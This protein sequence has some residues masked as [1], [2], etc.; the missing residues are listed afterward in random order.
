M[1]VRRKGKGKRQGFLH[2]PAAQPATARTET[3]EDGD[4]EETKIRWKPPQRVVT[5]LPTPPVAQT[6]LVTCSNKR[7]SELMQQVP[8]W[9]DISK[10]DCIISLTAIPTRV[11]H[12][13][14][15]RTLASLCEGQLLPPKRVILNVCEHY[16]RKF[17][18]PTQL[19]HQKLALLKSRFPQLYVNFTED[20]GPATK[21]LGLYNVPKEVVDVSKCNVVVVDDDFVYGKT[22]TQYHMLAMQLYQS[23]FVGIDERALVLWN[24]VGSNSFSFSGDG[25][26]TYHDIFYDNYHGY[27][28]GWMSFCMRG[29]LVH[30][31]KA[32]FHKTVESS[33]E[34]IS[35]DDLFFTLYYLDR[36]L[37]GV[38]MHMFFSEG[39]RPGS[40][41][42]DALRLR[43][44]EHSHRAAME[45]QAFAKANHTPDQLSKY[46]RWRPAKLA[47]SDSIPIPPRYL[48]SN[49]SNWEY[50]AT[51]ANHYQTTQYDLKYI[52]PSLM[53]LTVSCF[54]DPPLMTL[55]EKTGLSQL[56]LTLLRADNQIA[57]TVVLPWNR[58]AAARKATF[59]VAFPQNEILEQE[60]HQQR[61][62]PTLVQ[63][64]ADINVSCH[65]SICTIL[66]CMPHMPYRFF[67]DL[68]AEKFV[69]TT[70]PKPV[71]QTYQKLR[72]PSYRADLFRALYLWEHGGLYTDCK[73]V[74]YRS[75]RPYLA[76]RKRLYVRSQAEQWGTYNAV[77]YE[78]LPRSPVLKGY[79]TEAMY[80]V[81]FEIY[82]H[83]LLHVTGPCVLNSHVPKEDKILLKTNITVG[84]RWQES[85]FVKEEHGGKIIM[86]SS[87]YG[88]YEE[89]KNKLQHY[90]RY[91]ET[92]K[93]FQSL[94]Y[95]AQQK[96]NGIGKIV[97]INLDRCETRRQKMEQFLQQLQAVPNQRIPALHDETPEIDFARFIGRTKLTKKEVAC[98]LS[99]IKAITALRDAPGEWFLVVEDDLEFLSAY[100]FEQTL[101]EILAQAPE[102]AEIVKLH[103]LNYTKDRNLPDFVP[104]VVGRMPSTTAYAIRKSGVRH[105][106][107]KFR[108]TKNN[109]ITFPAKVQIA[110]ADMFIYTLAKTY[111]YRYNFF[112]APHD[113]STIHQQHMVWHRM[114]KMRN[115]EMMLWQLI[116]RTKDSLQAPEKPSHEPEEEEKPLY[117]PP[118]PPP[119]KD[120]P[121]ERLLQKQTMTERRKL[122][123]RRVLFAN[124]ANNKEQ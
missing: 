39:D 117:L 50:H 112:E 2:D 21:F 72:A 75:L 18:Y 8:R 76:G 88:Y 69:E 95:L 118:P 27:L 42:V 102:D 83:D 116:G 11:L 106:L 61:N 111:E 9:Y 15:E 22:L 28:F 89:T 51:L 64:A 54:H 84:D 121:Q 48:L 65:V 45:K 4:E 63:T 122:A 10:T 33:P 1:G 81:T 16:R 20:V 49:V 74:M 29:A 57:Y 35:H 96:I 68:Q 99:H 78:Q 58:Q 62:A 94:P 93:V 46:H 24:R 43:P 53:A 100:W 79:L 104:W 55:D 17:N 7:L 38:G 108:V 110:E 34:M 87:Y 59:F 30:D 80:N 124:R 73:M 98:S 70:F 119:E 120:V 36:N 109:E 86:K 92:R 105:V 31:A 52:S 101:E 6:S 32:F 85:S 3:P 66:N 103:T 13:E 71:L 115:F 26:R 37:Y 90:S 77:M 40:E 47:T 82:G 91:Y 123:I 97:W 12:Q 44:S 60:P 41:R 67:N 25:F 5:S 114:T 19:F 56:Q 23:D 113:E 107:E 14:F